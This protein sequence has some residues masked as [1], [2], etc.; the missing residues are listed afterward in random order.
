MTAPFPE[1]DCISSDERYVVCEDQAAPAT[2]GL[3]EMSPGLA[4]LWSYDLVSKQARRITDTDHYAFAGKVLESHS[5]LVF[6]AGKQVYLV[7]LATNA[8]ASLPLPSPG[9]FAIGFSW[10]Y[11]VYFDQPD[12]AQPTKVRARD[13]ATG[14]DIALPQ[15]DAVYAATNNADGNH[16]PYL[17]LTGDTLFVSLATGR[18]QSSNVPPNNV[19][20]PDAA[21]TL[22]E[23][24]HI[25]EGGSQLRPVARYHGAASFPI[26]ANPRLVVYDFI[27]WDRAEDRWVKFSSLPH[28]QGPVARLNGNTLMTL[29]A[30]QEVTIYDTA[31]LR[32]AGG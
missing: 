30:G 4:T 25:V 23:L 6:S 27:A 32:T 13:L 1:A 16:I 29:S 7:D 10:P 24:D 3:P 22:Y 26:G 14:Q 19:T 21:T 9:P 17:V 2:T 15:V 5:T 28:G 20:G 12:P 31:R 18:I 8:I 11:L